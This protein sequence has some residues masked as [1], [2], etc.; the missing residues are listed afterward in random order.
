[1]SEIECPQAVYLWNTELPY[2]Q[3]I[4]VEE[5][6]GALLLIDMLP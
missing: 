4:E 5:P 2:H 3:G 1:M 6:E